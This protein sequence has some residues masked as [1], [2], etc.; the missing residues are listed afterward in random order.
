MYIHSKSI[1]SR[2]QLHISKLQFPPEFE[3]G[4]GEGMDMQLPNHVYNK[5]KCHSVSENKR[6]Q[7]LHEKKEHSTAVSNRPTSAGAYGL[8]FHCIFGTDIHILI[9][10][11]M[12]NV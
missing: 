8:S 9:T 10:L 7:K 1:L 11:S 4:D 2:L 12:S 3:S 5:L 6:S